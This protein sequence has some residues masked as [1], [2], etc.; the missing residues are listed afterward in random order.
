MNEGLACVLATMNSEGISQIWK[1]VSSSPA[2][3]REAGQTALMEAGVVRR[4]G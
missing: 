1:R 4:H 2:M 3:S